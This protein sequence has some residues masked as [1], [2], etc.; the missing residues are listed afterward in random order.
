[1]GEVHQSVQ[2]DFEPWSLALTNTQ[3]LLMT[4]N[5]VSP[6]IHKLSEDRRVT[7]FASTSPAKAWNIS[8]SD[9]DEVFVSTNSREILVLNMSGDR[10][11]QLSCGQDWCRIACLTTGIVAVITDGVYWQKPKIID[12][13]DQVIHTWSGKL[14]SGKSILRKGQNSI[15][16]DNFGRVFVPD[17]YNNQVYVLPPR[18][19]TMALLDKKHGIT[20]PTA[21]CV[22]KCGDVWLGCIDGTVHVMQ[23]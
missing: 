22:D 13:S 16:C 23:L 17:T 6:L 15:A 11:K 4:R 18:N 3:E 8:V 19:D 1:M 10:V 12:K 21:V 9:S 20:S 7:T 14:D 5:D 2:L